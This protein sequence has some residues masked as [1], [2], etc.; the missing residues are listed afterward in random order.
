MGISH[1]QVYWAGKESIFINGKYIYPYR[2]FLGTQI[3]GINAL[4]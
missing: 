2:F 4:G 1:G 3:P